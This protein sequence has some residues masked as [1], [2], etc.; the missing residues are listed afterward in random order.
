MSEIKKIGVLTSGG[1]A[2]GMNPAVRAVVRAAAKYGMETLGI[3]GGYEGLM[4]GA[5]HPLTGM[6]VDDIIARGGTILESAR[7]AEY[8]SPAG[9]QKAAKQCHE[10]G[11]DALVVVGGDGSFRG[12]LD[13]S[14]NGGIQVIGLPGTIDNDIGYTEYTIGLDTAIN[15]CVECAE[16]LN[17]TASSHRRCM[18]MEVMGRGAGYIAMYAGIASGADVVLVP[19]RDV[20][21]DRD[22]ILPIKR[23]KEKGKNHFLVL[24]AEGIPSISSIADVIREK[25][26][27]DC[28]H[29]KLGHIQRGGRPTAAERIYATQMGAEAVHLLAKG[30]YN[31]VVGM[32]D[33]KVVDYDIVEA[34]TMGKNMPEKLFRLLEE[35]SL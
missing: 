18:V 11:I 10:M 4:N 17:D 19:E 25:T 8:N 3:Q 22:I 33:G 23:A 24:V 1:D 34:L 14:V 21:I 28:R 31:R 29:V 6:D 15:T 27:V 12:A 2:P 20:D 16:R 30:V 26:G 32:K 5:I 9:V 13:L 7:S 35:M